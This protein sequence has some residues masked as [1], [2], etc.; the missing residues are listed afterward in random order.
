MAKNYDLG[1]LRVKERTVDGKTGESFHVYAR[2]YDEIFS[3]D[4]LQ[5]LV[6]SLQDVL[7]AT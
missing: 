6:T 1:S 5:D 4:E 7:D 3:R 2:F